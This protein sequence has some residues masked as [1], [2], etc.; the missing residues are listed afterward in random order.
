MKLLRGCILFYSIF[1]EQF[2]IPQLT[3]T[4]NRKVPDKQGA[5]MLFS[6]S[7]VQILHTP[8]HAGS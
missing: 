6:K 8:E 3:D 2:I 1:H 7:G 5:K 4:F